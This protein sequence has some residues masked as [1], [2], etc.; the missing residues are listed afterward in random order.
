MVRSLECIWLNRRKE[1]GGG[2]K[3][4][5]RNHKRDLEILYLRNVKGWTFPKIGQKYDITKARARQLY[6]R[7]VKDKKKEHEASKKMGIGA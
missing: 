2:M 5:P 7:I 1:R 3:F 4:Q 6:C